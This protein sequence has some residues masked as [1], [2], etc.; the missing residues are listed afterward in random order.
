M[1]RIEVIVPD[2]IVDSLTHELRQLPIEGYTV[3]PVLMGKGTPKKQDIPGGVSPKAYLLLFFHDAIPIAVLNTLERVVNNHGGVVAVS[4]LN[5]LFS[6][7]QNEKRELSA[8]PQN[9]FTPS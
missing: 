6:T 1:Q 7:S 5:H 8:N 4:P 9:P 3:I 2:W